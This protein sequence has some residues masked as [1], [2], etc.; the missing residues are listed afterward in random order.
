[1]EVRL[2]SGETLIIDI[3]TSVFGVSASETIR[4]SVTWEFDSKTTIHVI[5]P[6]L[7]LESKLACLRS[8]D[9]THRQDQKHIRLMTHV[10]LAWFGE[11]LDSPPDVYR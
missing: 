6:L 10:L 9:Q 5:H 2:A 3:L 8:L 11:Q 4:S 1:L 7:L